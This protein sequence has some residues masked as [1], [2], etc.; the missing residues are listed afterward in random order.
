MSDGGIGGGDDDRGGGGTS[1]GD[2]RGGCR[3]P[4]GRQ[5]FADLLVVDGIHC[6][7]GIGGRHPGRGSDD[8]RRGRIMV[9]DVSVGTGAAMVD[10]VAWTGTVGRQAAEAVSG[11][12]LSTYPMILPDARTSTS[13]WL[14]S[15]V[16]SSSAALGTTR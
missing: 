2:G 13:I 12:F 7:R 15:C 9:V 3:T 4:S 16:P 10:A 5:K 1:G 11:N 14:V 8:R 6:V